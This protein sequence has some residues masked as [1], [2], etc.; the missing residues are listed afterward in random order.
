MTVG[1]DA[2]RPPVPEAPSLLETLSQARDVAAGTALPL[3]LPTADAARRSAAALVAQLDDYLLPRLGRLDAPTLAVVG[4]STGAGKSTLVN[5]LVRAPVSPAGV[6][7]PT[8]HTPV[9][10]C[11]PMDAPWFVAPNL[12]PAMSRSHP[13]P[14]LHGL[15]EAGVD[16]PDL[17]VVMAPA[18]NPGLALMDVPDIDSVVAANR[19][20][21]AEL[22]A[23]ADMWLFL[24]TAARY[25]DAVP[26]DTLRQARERGV[27]VAVVLDR[28][29][30]EQASEVALHLARMLTSQTLGDAPLFII[31]ESTLDGQGMLP[32]QRVVPVRT[33]L[34]S[35]AR[36]PV[37]RASVTRRTVSGAVRSVRARLGELSAAADE[38]V[39][40]AEDL[41]GHVRSAYSKADAAAQ[42]AFTDGSLLGGEV[43]LAWWEELAPYTVSRRGAHAP[44]ERRRRTRPSPADRV[45]RAAVGREIQE[46]LLT[47]VT[48]QLIET[49]AGA[50]Q[51]AQTAWGEHPAGRALLAEAAVGRH[52]TAVC[53][54]DLVRQL[55]RD[56]QNNTRTLVRAARSAPL[57]GPA[58]G[59]PAKGAP[60]SGPSSTGP[61][62]TG[63]ASTG[64]ALTGP[65]PTAAS[66]A[67]G[68]VAAG[69]RIVGVA[70][71]DTVCALVTLA[72][73]APTR[74]TAPIL[75]PA[76][77]GALRAVL[78]DELIRRLAA[79][80]RADLRER[81]RDFFAEERHGYLVQLNTPGVDPGAAARLRTAA[82][83]IRAAAESGVAG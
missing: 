3:A 20:L 24:T 64:P 38:Q 77:R 61:G 32:E 39:A 55:V 22:L 10:A 56:W 25:A 51:R 37:R 35:L 74:G 82:T 57:G 30:L 31:P 34:D 78:G 70:D 62:S 67:G 19:H 9:L 59:G 68:G 75:D 11:H 8:T 21:A 44:R 47:A 18:L 42:D 81:V 79:R 83:R 46:A 5:S 53:R 49:A 2:E 43:S 1:D 48:V 58:K 27:P 13:H 16:E 54:P 69:T 71:V 52:E 40:A 28:V 15:M 12:L 50:D 6:L 29:P 33:W 63:L 17:Q 41:A 26:W 73:F 36:D 72:T 45:A 60:S 23:A 14:H 80:A 66:P 4:G 65:G 76:S 7:R